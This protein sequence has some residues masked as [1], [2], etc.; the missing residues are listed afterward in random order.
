M[1]TILK[2][3][4]FGLLASA[5]TNVLTMDNSVN[6]AIPTIAQQ[7]LEITSPAAQEAATITATMA[8]RLATLAGSTWNS[9]TSSRIVK[10][11][12]EYV[13][14]C[15][16]F[17]GTYAKFPTINAGQLISSAQTSTTLGWSTLSTFVAQ[18]YNA[19]T[20]ENAHAAYNT[21]KETLAAHPYATGGTLAAVVVAGASYGAY[22]ARE[23]AKDKARLEDYL[24]KLAIEKQ[25]QEVAFKAKFDRVIAELNSRN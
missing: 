21:V 14:T 7:A 12:C 11:A 23:A 16:G 25:E 10:S 6:Q 4:S 5:A 8:Q 13:P 22:K 19:M 1:K 20:L 3:L 17:K 9:I 2:I 24:R 18:A 15:T